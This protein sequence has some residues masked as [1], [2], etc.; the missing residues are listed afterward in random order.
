M[1]AGKPTEKPATQSE[2]HLDR[3]DRLVAEIARPSRA[4]VGMLDIEAE[5]T[6]LRTQVEELQREQQSRAKQPTNPD[7]H[8]HL[9]LDG[10][11]ETDSDSPSADAM[12]VRGPG[13]IGMRRAPAWLVLAVAIVAAVAYVVGQI[14]AHPRPDAV[15]VTAP[16]HPVVPTER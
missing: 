12:S 16:A 6:P 10:R 15:P 5:L 11:A 14:A 9:D 3:V 13:G 7:I 4:P 8:V 1:T 2:V